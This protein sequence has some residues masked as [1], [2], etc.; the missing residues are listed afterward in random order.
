VPALLEGGDGG[1]DFAAKVSRGVIFVGVGH[2]EDGVLGCRFWRGRALCDD[3]GGGLVAEGQVG[4]GEGG[5]FDGVV[6][7]AEGVAVLFEDIELAWTTSV[8]VRVKRLQA[9]A[10][11]GQRG[12]GFLFACAA[13]ERWGV[14][15]A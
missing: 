10:V 11:F 4:G 6:V 13:D 15:D 5:F 1:D 2:V 8:P 14:G 7:A 9:S 3:V 12:G